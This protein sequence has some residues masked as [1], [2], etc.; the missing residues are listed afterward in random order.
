MRYDRARSIPLEIANSSDST[1]GSPQSAPMNVSSSSAETINLPDT[2]EAVIGKIS[3]DQ[4]KDLTAENVLSVEG[5]DT[6]EN[7]SEFMR[8]CMIPEKCTPEPEQNG[9]KTAVR[10]KKCRN[11]LDKKDDPS[12]SP[13]SKRLKFNK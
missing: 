9:A 11:M 4:R 2:K 5:P 13:A 12:H 7:L 3:H 1:G 10:N 8:K 6:W